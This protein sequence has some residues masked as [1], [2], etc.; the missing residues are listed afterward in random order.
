M[1]SSES[2]IMNKMIA[3][4]EKTYADRGGVSASDLIPDHPLSEDSLVNELVFSMLMWESSIENAKKSAARIRDSLVDLNELRVCA[5]SEI[6]VILGARTARS[7]ERARRILSVLNTIY[8]REN[9][10]SL[11]VL[12]EMGK[13]EV[14]E[15]LDGIDG[16]PIY[17]RN[18]LILLCFDWHAFPLDERLV[19][20]LNATGLI[21]PSLGIE[22]QS[23]RFE[24]I[25]RANESKRVY[26]LIEQWAQARRTPRSGASKR[27]TPKGAKS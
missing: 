21:D 2:D 23:Q 13:R 10:V 15:Y 1:I 12:S 5:P 20:L 16:L 9:R 22:Q 11:S 8:Q 6:S 18:R 27:A 14:V 4:I 19:R 24:R 7:E 25:V 3:K 17:V 26:T